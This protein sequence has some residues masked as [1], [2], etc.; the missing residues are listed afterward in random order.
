MWKLW[1]ADKTNIEAASETLA[2]HNWVLLLGWW[3]MTIILNQQ[4]EDNWIYEV[5]L[6]AEISWLLSKSWIVVA[7]Q[8]LHDM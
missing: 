8:L 2:L 7:I 4:L 5:K 6:I 3:Y 1:S